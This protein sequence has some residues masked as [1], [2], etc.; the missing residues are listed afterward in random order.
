MTVHTASPV[1]LTPAPDRGTAGVVQSTSMT[2]HYGALRPLWSLLNGHGW[3]PC[4]EDMAK[5][6]QGVCHHTAAPG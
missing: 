2:T 5:R 6:Y 1:C 4:A 3:N